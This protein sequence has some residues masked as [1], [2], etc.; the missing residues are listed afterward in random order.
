MP[1]ELIS[2][3]GPTFVASENNLADSSSL[4]A[5]PGESSSNACEITGVIHGASCDVDFIIEDSGGSEIISVN[6]ASPSG[7]GSKVLNPFIPLSDNER[8]KLKVTNTSG[9][10][11]DFAIIG[12]EVQ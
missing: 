10:G 8:M 12:Y 1:E 7:E 11:A 4:Y 6:I 9:S 3:D 2:L 5:D